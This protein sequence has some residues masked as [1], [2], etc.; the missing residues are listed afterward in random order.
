MFNNFF[1]KFTNHILLYHSTY[2][3][4]PSN[5]KGLIHNVKPEI[6]YKQIK[7]LKYYY[8]I[9]DIDELINSNKINGKASI[10]FDDAYIS[11]YQ[12]TIPLLKLLNI[13]FTIYVNGVTLK[14]KAIWRDKIRYIINNK[15]V[16]ELI[17]LNKSYFDKNKISKKEFYKKTKTNKI[18]SKTLDKILDNFLLKKKIDQKEICYCYNSYKFF[19]KDPLITYGNHTY[20]HY[21]LSS[22]SEDE[23]E[24]EV[25]KNHNL[26]LELNL[27]TSKILSI[28]FGGY[29]DYN[30]NLYNILK[31]Y[32]YTGCLISNANLNSSR[33]LSNNFIKILNR[34]M[35]EP[36]YKK[37]KNQTY[38]LAIKYVLNKILNK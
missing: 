1:N 22:L 29:S 30:S 12:E 21:V 36:E 3:L 19:D 28:P 32:K 11:V 6:L 33:F 9:I 16:D 27:K 20:N 15:L 37:F 10:T 17:D 5:L 34:Y 31:S 35:V 7:W 8:D 2:T 18:N 4:E 24:E 14:N 13:P 25:I 23:I 38:K 26:L